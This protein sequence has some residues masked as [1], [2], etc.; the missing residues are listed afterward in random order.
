MPAFAALGPPDHRRAAPRAGKRLQ[1]W[2]GRACG[3]SAAKLPGRAREVPS[4]TSNTSGCAQA[5]LKE[6]LVSLYDVKDAQCVSLFG[7]RTQVRKALSEA[8]QR[9]RE[10]GSGLSGSSRLWLLDLRP[11]PS[12]PLP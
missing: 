1:G 10:A 11:R 8:A 3:A 2:M 4:N 12:R 5:E 6:K 7:F 9:Q